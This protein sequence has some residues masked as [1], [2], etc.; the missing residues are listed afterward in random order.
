MILKQN[1]R[2]HESFLGTDVLFCLVLLTE[3][4]RTGRQN[5]SSLMMIAQTLN[6]T[7][8][9]VLNTRYRR[10]HQPKNWSC[11]KF[12]YSIS[13]KTPP[14]WIATRTPSPTP[15]SIQGVSV[16]TIIEEK[17]T[18]HA[19]NVSQKPAKES[20]GCTQRLF[21]LWYTDFE[22]L[23]GE[24]TAIRADQITEPWKSE[25]EY[26]W[27]LSRFE[28]E[29]KIALFISVQDDFQST[30]SSELDILLPELARS[31]NWNVDNKKKQM[32]DQNRLNFWDI[33]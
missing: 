20:F 10:V 22:S 1:S 9:S 24:V 32:R 15:C 8:H 25:F 26:Q 4:Y 7:N 6:F 11:D 17:R 12:I 23:T 2:K 14:V 13:Q 5:W 19:E 28:N 30:D 18:E 33:Q 3:C 21:L 31:S 16:S 27:V 29:E